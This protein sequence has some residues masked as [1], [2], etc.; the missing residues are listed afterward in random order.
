MDR[1]FRYL[2]IISFLAVFATANAQFDDPKTLEVGPHVGVSYYMGDLNPTLPFAQSQLQYGGLVRFNYN[3]RWT[4]RFD[5]S[6]AKVMGSDEVAQWRPE[7]GLNFVTNINDFSIVAEFNFLEYYTGN[8]KKNISPYIF[9]GISVFQ[10]TPFAEVN[11][12]LVNLRYLDPQNK[13]LRYTEPPLADDAKWFE[14]MTYKSMPMSLSIPFGMGV[15]FSLSRHMGATI[16]WRMQKTFTD[17]L[18]DVATVYPEQ[19]SVYTS[20]DGTVYDLSDPTGNYHAGQQRGNAT[21]NDWFGM[22]RVSL[23]WKFNL[24]DGRGCNLSKF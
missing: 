17:Y 14:K 19:H 15:K 10:Y 12:E 13:S 8:P 20:E 6:R 24:P 4:F 5:Y 9:G 21:F 22:A 18:D 11:G 1:R 3:N 7:R 2:L 16:E 23:T